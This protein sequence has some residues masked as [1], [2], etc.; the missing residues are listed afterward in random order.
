[1]TNFIL[2]FVFGFGIYFILLGISRLLKII[3][4][5]IKTKAEK[6]RRVLEEHQAAMQALR[7]LRAHIRVSRSSGKDHVISNYE[8]TVIE[9]ALNGVYTIIGL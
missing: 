9:D 6:K 8:E 1:M 2:G 7:I 4:K 5:E 3:H